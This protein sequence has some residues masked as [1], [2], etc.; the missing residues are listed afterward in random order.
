MAIDVI[1]EKHQ[2]I[3][4]GRETGKIVDIIKPPGTPYFHLVVKDKHGTEEAIVDEFP[5]FEDAKEAMDSINEAIKSDDSPWDVN[6]FKK[7]CP[8]R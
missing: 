1:T 8:D 5:T 7:V 2:M 6:E 4:I 3:M